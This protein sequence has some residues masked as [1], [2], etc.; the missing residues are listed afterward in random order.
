MQPV[1]I[2]VHVVKESILACKQSFSSS[3]LSAASRDVTVDL[4]EESGSMV[5]RQLYAAVRSAGILWA[6]ET[7]LSQP[8]LVPHVLQPHSLF[9]I[10]L[11]FLCCGAQTWTYN[12]RCHLK[13]L[14]F[15]LKDSNW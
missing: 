15:A 6:A 5:S 1:L 9:S 7:H 10:S 3:N 4:K 14:K 8:C 11:F 12:S 2:F 13:L